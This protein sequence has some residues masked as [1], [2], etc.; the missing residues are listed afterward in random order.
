MFT[1]NAQIKK[2]QQRSI[3][4]SSLQRKIHIGQQIVHIVGDVTIMHHITW[5]LNNQRVLY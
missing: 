2:H 5:R 1:M 3:A 4:V